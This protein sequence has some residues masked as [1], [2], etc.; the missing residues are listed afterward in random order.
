VAVKRKA[1]PDILREMLGG[2]EKI[3]AARLG[4]A[5][6]KWAISMSLSGSA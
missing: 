5:I 1:E 2:R 3:A 4:Q 6:R